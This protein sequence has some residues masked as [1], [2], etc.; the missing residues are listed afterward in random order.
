MTFQLPQVVAELIETV[1]F[2]GKFEGG[3]HGLVNLFASSERAAVQRRPERIIALWC[4]L[5]YP[6]VGKTPNFA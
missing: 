1:G 4:R 3:E 5:F 6:P 2:G